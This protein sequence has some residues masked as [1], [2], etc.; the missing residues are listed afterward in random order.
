MF[1]HG[2]NY[3][4]KSVFQSG[5]RPDMVKSL[6]KRVCEL[7]A[8]PGNDIQHSYM[9]EYVSHRV[10]LTIPED[11]TAFLRTPRCV[12]ASISKWAQKSPSNEDAAKR[13]AREL[14]GIVAEAEAQV[15]GENSENNSGYG[16]LGQSLV[17]SGRFEAAIEGTFC[18]ISSLRF[19]NSEKCQWGPSS[20]RFEHPGVVRTQLR[21]STARESTVRSRERVFEMVPDHPERRCLSLSLSLTL[22]TEPFSARREFSL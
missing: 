1:D 8:A 16:N 14:T 20:R 5:P 22:E 3:Y 21:P 2:S 9:F 4:L 17:F 10:G 18:T 19:P 11:A 15:S 7:N 12:T 13:A 6:F